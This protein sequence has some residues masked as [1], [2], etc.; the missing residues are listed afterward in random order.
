GLLQISVLNGTMRPF[1]LVGIENTERR[2]DLTGPTDVA[3]DRAIA[4]RTGGSAAFRQFIRNELKP[5][6][7][8]RYSVTQES[9]IVGESLAG[10]FNVETFHIEPDM[11]DTKIAYYPSLWWNGAYAVR[12]G[13]ELIAGGKQAGRTL[14]VANSNEATLAALV[15]D[16]VTMLEA[17]SAAAFTWQ[18]VEMRDETHGTIYHPAALQAFRRLFK[19]EEEQE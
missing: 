8:A 7:E 12:N 16:F 19:P 3:E 9:A 6:I 5:T 10:H 17:S 4:P 13:A 15:R 11:L 18:H 14:H 2:R 1:L